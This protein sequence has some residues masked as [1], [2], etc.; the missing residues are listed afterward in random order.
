MLPAS[1]GSHRKIRRFTVPKDA[2][3]A[4]VLRRLVDGGHLEDHQ[5]RGFV[6]VAEGSEARQHQD[7][8]EANLTVWDG[9]V[10]D[11]DEDG[12]YTPC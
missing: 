5:W 1:H 3:V 11:L 2:R 9:T 6:E 4:Q 10:E 12:V 8:A 7:I